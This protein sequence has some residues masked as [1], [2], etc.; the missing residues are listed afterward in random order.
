V[1]EL[2]LVLGLARVLLSVVYR[3]Y[4]T[5]ELLVLVRVV[6]ELVGHGG[7]CVRRLGMKRDTSAEN[8]E[9]GGRTVDS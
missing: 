3:G 9:D 2:G 1:G 4:A 6:L 8:D 7:E 5:Y